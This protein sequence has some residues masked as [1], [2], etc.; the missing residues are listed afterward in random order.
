MTTTPARILVIKLGALGDVAQA[1]P[2]MQ[3]IRD[4]HAGAALTLL[5]TPAFAPTFRACPWFAEVWEDGR[6]PG[7]RIDAWLAL[8]RRLRGGGFAR[9]Y[10]LQ[11]AGRTDFYFSLLLPGPRPEWVGTAA[12]ASHRHVNPARDSMHTEERLADQ[13]AAAGIAAVPAPDLSWLAGDVAR[14]GLKAPY[15]LLAPGAAPHRPAKRWPAERF[16]ALAGRLAGAGLMPVVLGAAADAPLAATISDHAGMSVDL[17]GRTTIADLA[18][19]GRGAALGVGNDTGPMHWLAAAGAPCLTLFSAESDP[20]L[21]A[22]RGDATRWLRRDDLRDLP[23][24]DVADAALALARPGRA[25]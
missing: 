14:F 1:L 2:A 8:R 11:T 18:A 20:A 21:C 3:A 6:A 5:T 19:L 23:V 4:H 7:W 15:A 12:G 10:D 16:G 9:V 22:P 25:S 13:L 17:A 24:N